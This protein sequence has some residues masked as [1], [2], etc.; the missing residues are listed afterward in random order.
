MPGDERST[1]ALQPTGIGAFRADQNSPGDRLVR[2]ESRGRC[3]AFHLS[4]VIGH[5][6]AERSHEVRPDE[7]GL[8]ERHFGTDPPDFHAKC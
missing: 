4:C 5:V 3:L 8:D 7:T 2:P 6:A 1:T